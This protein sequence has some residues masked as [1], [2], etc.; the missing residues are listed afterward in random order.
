MRARLVGGFAATLSALAILSSVSAPALVRAAAQARAQASTRPSAFTVEG[1]TVQVQDFKGLGTSPGSR[2]FRGK[3]GQ[4]FFVRGLLALPPAPFSDAK[5]VELVI[6]F[7]TSRDGPSLR[8]VELLNGS[9]RV[10]HVP[11]GLGLKGDFQQAIFKPESRANAWQVEPIRVGSQ[12]FVRLTVQNPIGF[13]T[14]IDPGEFIVYG[15]DAR[16]VGLNPST[17][18]TGSAASVT[19]TNAVI[20]AV[21]AN[22]DLLWYSHTGRVDG[23]RRWRSD[24][25]QAV[26]TGWNFT[27]VFPGDNGVVYGINQADELMWYRHVGRGDGTFTWS[28]APKRVGTGWRFTHVFPAAGGVIYAIND[29]GELL[30]ARHDGRD[31]GTFQWSGPQAVGTGWKFAHVFASDGGVIYAVTEGGDLLWYRH[32]GRADGTPRWAAGSGNRVGEGWNFP[33]VFAAGAGVIYAVTP[34]GDL[35][36]YRH[37]GF[38]DGTARWAAPAGKTVGTGWTVKQIFSGATLGL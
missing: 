17:T 1:N 25:G 36:W 38:T 21:T 10:F 4:K 33:H 32:D 2:R 24:T 15:V 5:L 35:L 16:F 8:G 6:R 31:A 29:A 20:Y 22:D 12:T 19:G 13:D 28:D 18:T 27:R 9:H 30:W 37:D 3:P 11:M 26:G 14:V 34:S 7:R 23:T